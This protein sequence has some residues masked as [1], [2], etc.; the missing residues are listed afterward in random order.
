MNAEKI[1][2]LPPD[3]KKEAVL[4]E[5]Y[6]KSSPNGVMLSPRTIRVYVFAIKS[7]IR[8]K[9]EIDRDYIVSF[10]QKHPRLEVRAAIIYYLKWKGF[11]DIAESI[12]RVRPKEKKHREIPTY[13]EFMKVIKFLDAE[14]RMIALFLLNTGARCHEVFKLL[15]KDIKPNGYVE[16]STKGGYL[17]RVKL[18]DGFYRQL[19]EYI[20]NDVGIL[21]LEHLFY[22]KLNSN[23]D[24]KVKY[25]YKK[26]NIVAKRQLG[27]NIGTHDFRRFVAAY[28]YEK[29]GHDLKLVQSFLGHKKIET[30]AIYIEHLNTE[31]MLEKAG[32]ILNELPMK[33]RNRE[34]DKV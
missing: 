3:K 5:S 20:D 34:K 13:D 32:A 16:F 8:R 2:I 23:I 28:L 21:P 30:T 4:F 6:L 25:F 33:P 19:R 1:V 26:L 17:R 12:P 22:R 27:K 9:K 10:L 7:L 18:P 15:E 11:D 24:N 31:K 14:E 29:S